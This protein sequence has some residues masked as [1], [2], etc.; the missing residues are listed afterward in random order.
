VCRFAGHRRWCRRR[1]A[2]GAGLF[3]SHAQCA[4]RSDGGSSRPRPGRSNQRRWRWPSRILAADVAEQGRRAFKTCSQPPNPKAPALSRHRS[5]H[6][7]ITDISDLYRGPDRGPLRITL[8]FSKAVMTDLHRRRRAERRGPRSGVA[9]ELTFGS[10]RNRRAESIIRSCSSSASDGHSAAPV[11]SKGVL[12]N[13][14]NLRPL[15]GIHPAIPGH[16]EKGAD[17]R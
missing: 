8:P 4:E 14:Q 7:P 2:I 17:R 5:D 15:S 16:L 1:H 13:P 9:L 12:G 6:E 3:E 11:Q 10:W